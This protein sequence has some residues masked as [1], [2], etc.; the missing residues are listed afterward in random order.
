VG[1]QRKRIDVLIAL[2]MAE[3]AVDDAF[4]VVVLMSA[5]T[6]LTPALEV[7]LEAGKRVELASWRPDHS[8]G[9][10]LALPGHNLWCHWLD[11]R[12]FERVRDNTDYT[13]P[14]IGTG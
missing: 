4:D 3:G 6:D 8:Y 14:S 12:D 7:V 9:S 5:D 10:R 2:E 1:G 13:R 11:R